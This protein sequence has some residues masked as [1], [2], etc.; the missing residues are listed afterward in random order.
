MGARL[1][2][3]PGHSHT[4]NSIEVITPGQKRGFSVRSGRRDGEG[5]AEDFVKHDGTGNEGSDTA[6]FVRQIS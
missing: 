1:T 3:G 5:A 6:Q 4:E 2:S